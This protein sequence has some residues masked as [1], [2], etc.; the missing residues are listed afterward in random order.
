MLH[1]LEQTPEQLRDWFAQ[2]G[3]PAL[4]GGAGAEVALPEAG[5]RRSTR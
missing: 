2:R 3:L 1:L 5:R 4:S